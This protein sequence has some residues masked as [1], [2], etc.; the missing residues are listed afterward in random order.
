MRAIRRRGFPA[1][2]A[3]S[4]TPSQSTSCAKRANRRA[5]SR[6]KF[7]RRG[8]VRQHV[9][10]RAPEAINAPA[11]WAINEQ[12]S[13]GARVQPSQSRRDLRFLWVVRRRRAHLVRC[14]GIALR[15]VRADC[16]L[17][18][19]MCH[20]IPKRAGRPRDDRLP[21]T[22]PARRRVAE[23]PER[24]VQLQGKL[25]FMVRTSSG[26]RPWQSGPR[27]PTDGRAWS[28]SGPARLAR[29]DESLF[30]GR[31]FTGN[32]VIKHPPGRI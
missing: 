9:N 19:D 29:P 20:R 7:Q 2:P 16:T 18:R 17:Q 10:T 30:T 21:Q 28:N 5:V 15:P 4:M 23:V 31:S 12:F 32:G 25:V 8:A 14:F 6:F 27:L 3:K 11:G 13:S 24:L 26:P 1:R 22:R